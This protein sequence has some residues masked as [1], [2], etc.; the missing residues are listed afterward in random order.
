[1]I[2]NALFRALRRC[3]ISLCYLLLAA[4]FYLP[5]L[6]GVRTFPDGDFTHH[7]LPFSLFQQEA[8]RNGQLP[9]WN[10]HTY[11][12]HPFLADTQAAVFYPVSNLLLLL[13]LPWDGPGARL[14]WLQV[15]ALIHLALAGW[16][17]FLL[18]RT[19]TGNRWAAFVAGCAFAFS[20]YLTG[21][22]PLQLAVLRTAIW[23]PLLLW[24]LWHAMHEPT[25][26]R[27]WIGAALSYATMF[28]AGHPQTFLH[29]SYG[30]GAWLVW[31]FF[32]REGTGSDDEN[33][34]TDTSHHDS[35]FQNA[36][37]RLFGLIAFCA[38]ALALSAMQLLP[39]LEFTQL[40]VRANVTYDYVSGGFPLQDTWQLLLPGVLT[41]FSPLYI[42]VIGL[43][44]A[45]VGSAGRRPVALFF[46]LLALLFL[47]L[48]YGQNGFLYPLF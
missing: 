16:F 7:F 8:L 36:P 45:I 27:W 35:R 13:T 29:G 12:G 33:A 14:Y 41:Q 17:T 22:P 15:E 39:S 37:A 26:W 21:Y 3:P 47:L 9:L 32:R 40:S 10:P 44:L 31:L 25:K 30:M 38:L 5:L 20:G 18:V 6:L 11:S 2:S 34:V 28:L 1:M 42:G 48:S 23:L 43:G 24:L 19:L 4:L 46:A